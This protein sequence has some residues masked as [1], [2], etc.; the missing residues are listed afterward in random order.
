[1]FYP[2][3]FCRCYLIA[4]SK[5]DV[6]ARKDQLFRD[7]IKD[8]NPWIDLDDPDDQ[9]YI[10]DKKVNFYEGIEK[11]KEIPEGFKFDTHY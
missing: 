11:V 10:E 9:F 4:P 2:N 6:I 8:D 1:M 3:D 7:Y 5:E